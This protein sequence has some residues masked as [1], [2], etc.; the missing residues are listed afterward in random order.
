MND[1]LSANIVGSLS[2]LVGGIGVI[3]SLLIAFGVNITPDQHTAIEAFGALLL[4]IAGL[5]LHP[6][7]PIGSTAEKPPPGVGP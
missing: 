4:L 1:A 7:V 6:K 3:L 2:I 5:W